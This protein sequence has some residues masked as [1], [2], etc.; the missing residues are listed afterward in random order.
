VLDV[1]LVE[2]GLALVVDLLGGPEVDRGGGVHSDA[3]MSVFV[4]VGREESLTE[5]A[6]VCREYSAII[7][8]ATHRTSAVRRQ[9]WP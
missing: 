4:V 1:G 3:G 6:G 8:S 7:A 5:C 9:I 2:G